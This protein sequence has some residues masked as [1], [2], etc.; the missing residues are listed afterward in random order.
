MTEAKLREILFDWMQSII[1]AL[2]YG[3]EANRQPNTIAFLWH[4]EN[5]ARPKTPLLEGRL[6]S[7]NRIGRDWPGALDATL[8]NQPFYGDR[9]IMLYLNFMGKY[10]IDYMKAIRNATND[11]TQLG[12]LQSKGVAFV[13]CQPIL[14]AHEWLGTLPEDRATMDM[15]LR[16]YDTWHTQKGRPGIIEHVN[17]SGEI[18]WGGEPSEIL[19][20]NV[21]VNP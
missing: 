5:T 21:S 16:Y 10:A 8:G 12:P 6:T 18:D 14:D 3:N 11:P 1:P 19:T 2:W 13:D 4:M 20:G 9:E 15:R 17:M 7:E